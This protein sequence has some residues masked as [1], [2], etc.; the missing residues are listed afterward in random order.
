VLRGHLDGRVAHQFFA[1]PLLQH[2][3]GKFRPVCVPEGVRAQL[4]KTDLRSD[5]VQVTLP[6]RIGVV[7]LPNIEVAEQPAI[8]RHFSIFPTTKNI[9]QEVTHPRWPSS[10][11]PPHDR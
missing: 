3:L 5:P 9:D 6:H 2:K 1:G 7:G 4:R 11:C 10:S 8:H